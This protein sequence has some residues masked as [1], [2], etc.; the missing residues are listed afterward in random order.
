[1]VKNNILNLFSSSLLVVMTFFLFIHP[2]RYFLMSVESMEL[3]K[4]PEVSR[5]AK[6]SELRIS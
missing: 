3:S 6:G 1:M 5:V 2:Y 4:S